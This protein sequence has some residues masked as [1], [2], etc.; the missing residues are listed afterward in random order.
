[1]TDAPDQPQSSPRPPAKTKLSI[2]ERQTGAV[3]RKLAFGAL[4]VIALV[5]CLLAPYSWYMWTVTARACFNTYFLH[6][7]RPKLL[8]GDIGTWQEKLT[9]LDIS[10]FSVLII[11][12]LFTRLAYV[13]IRNVFQWLRRE[14]RSY[15]DHAHYT[16]L[17]TEDFDTLAIRLGLLG[18]LLSFLLAALTLMQ[19]DTGETPAATGTLESE[20]ATLLADD[21]AA[22]EDTTGR[23]ATSELS[24]Q[25]FLL[26]CASLVSTFVGTGVAYVISPCL[27]WLND[28]AV[29]RHQIGDAEAELVAEE[30]FRQISRTSERLAEF[31]AATT[32]LAEAA[33]HIT[34]FEAS[35]GQAATNLAALLTQLQAAIRTFEISNETGQDLAR[36]LNSL[37]AEHERLRTVLDQ[38]PDKLN[39]SMESMSRTSRRFKEAA[40]SGEVAFRELKSA[41][42]AAHESLNDTAQRTKVIWKLL[43]EIRDSLSALAKSDQV[44]ADEVLRLVQTMEDV[45]HSLRQFVEPMGTAAVPVGAIDRHSGPNVQREQSLRQEHGAT[46]LRAAPPSRSWWRRWFG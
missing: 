21:G 23:G 28:R 1:M 45:N 34:T 36:R 10:S 24:G 9:A 44:Q 31:Q 32:K 13:G 33:D 37:E 39:T 30:F 38:L 27:N 40:Q 22:A 2:R 8:E 20:I 26:L 3:S 46:R 29:G 12:L 16:V 14:G 42:G 35:V 25:M 15:F 17:F 18:T 6:E 7:G 43:H 11:S 5:A 19:Y 4:G 41:A